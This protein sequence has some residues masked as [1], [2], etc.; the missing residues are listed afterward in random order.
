MGKY[1]AL[2]VRKCLDY[3][4]IVVPVKVGIIYQ[5]KFDHEC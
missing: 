4:P 3:I 2:G 5:E 1:D